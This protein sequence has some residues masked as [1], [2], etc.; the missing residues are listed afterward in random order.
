MKTAKNPGGYVSFIT[1]ED[2]KWNAEMKRMMH[3]YQPDI[4]DNIP[5]FDKLSPTW[6]KAN[7]LKANKKRD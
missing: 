1:P 5:A 6:E 2:V 7:E 3:Q 4:P